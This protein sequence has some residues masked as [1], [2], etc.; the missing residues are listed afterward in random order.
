MK[1]VLLIKDDIAV[2]KQMV[3]SIDNV[4]LGVYDEF[5]EVDEA[6]YYD[7]MLPSKYNNGAWE[8]TDDFPY[9]NYPITSSN[10][11]EEQM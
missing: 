9:I 8:A 5:K 7:V 3:S 6:T 10:N 1:Y 4:Q 2:A 11:R